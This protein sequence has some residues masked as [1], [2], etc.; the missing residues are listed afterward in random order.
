MI[1]QIQ[2]LF[3]RTLSAPAIRA[4]AQNK[5]CGTIGS[6]KALA[7]SCGA[8]RSRQGWRS[9]GKRTGRRGRGTCGG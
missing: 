7:G 4:N 9:R 6:N 5:G 1:Q 8:F 3:G 2:L